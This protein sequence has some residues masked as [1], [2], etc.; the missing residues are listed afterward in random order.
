MIHTNFA[1]TPRF[2]SVQ[3]STSAAAADH[4]WFASWFDSPDYHKLY[5]YRSDA[6]AAGFIDALIGRLQPEEHA[7]ILDLGC[8]AGRHAIHLASKGFCVTGLDLA[9]ASI[10][11][12]R[13]SERP[14]LRF[15]RHDMRVPF[16]RDAFDYVFNM[17]TSFGYFED[18]DEHRL[19]V[20]NIA[21]ALHAGGR[22]VL[23]YLNVPYA[24]VRL[25]RSETRTIDGATYR[26]TRWSDS[27]HF[28]KRIRIE[29]DGQPAGEHVERV[30]K[31]T[32]VDFDEM[33]ARYGLAIEAVYGDYALRPYELQTS[34]RLILIA[35]RRVRFDRSFSRQVLA[36]AAEGLR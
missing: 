16:G 36:D 17:F 18:A 30:A 13:R 12:A 10:R 8:G 20:R 25:M 34:P 35:R 26:L 11:L 7:S 29:R 22:L 15:A 2:K 19:V 28:H 1:A 33:F 23:D 32:Y 27:T 14:G 6:E 5:A 31:F 3:I 24:E 4:P 9:A 21:R